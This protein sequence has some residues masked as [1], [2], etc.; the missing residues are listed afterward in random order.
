M[1]PSLLTWL[2]SVQTSQQI[3]SI[4]WLDLDQRHVFLFAILAAWLTW[5]DLHTA[6][7]HWSRQLLGWVFSNCWLT[8]LGPE[9]RRGIFW[10]NTD[11]F[12]KLCMYVLD[13][14]IG[15]FQWKII[16]WGTRYKKLGC[17]DLI[18][19]SCYLFLGMIDWTRFSYN[20]C[21]LVERV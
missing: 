18:L 10:M 6:S 5:L 21:W 16:T 9:A 3:L 1:T 2:R 14:T 17:K 20:Q 12:I 13:D 7:T 8:W 19:C 15:I 11:N 4:C